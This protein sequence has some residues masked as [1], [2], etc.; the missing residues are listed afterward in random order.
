MDF[1]LPA[2][3]ALPKFNNTIFYP[4][5]PQD[6]VINGV[7]A[8]AVPGYC[9]W[10]SFYRPSPFP[11]YADP[12]ASENQAW[13]PI[14]REHQQRLRRHVHTLLSKGIPPENIYVLG[15]S[16][17]AVAA[18]QLLVG[19]AV[20]EHL[21]LGGGIG[22]DGADVDQIASSA[23]FAGLSS[24]LP[25]LYFSYSEPPV[26][27]E[28]WRSCLTN[29]PGLNLQLE[30]IDSANEKIPHAIYLE[31]LETTLLWIQAPGDKKAEAQQVQAA[32]RKGLEDILA[33]LPP[34]IVV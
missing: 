19:L 9:A 3:Q 17:G 1:F 13:S 33:K 22:F 5:K 6:P 4:E 32:W 2:S 11:C 14:T 20:E 26:M 18:Q 8:W 23:A 24:P 34:Q 28:A 25:M 12:T 30:K 31:L 15:F 16:I 21:H 7:N 29:Y 10:T 27:S